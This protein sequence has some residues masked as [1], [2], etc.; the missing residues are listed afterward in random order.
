MMAGAFCGG[1]P[2]GNGP[3]FTVTKKDRL[4]VVESSGGKKGRSAE[5]IAESKRNY[6][7]I[8]NRPADVSNMLPNDIKA[9]IKQLYARILKIEGEKYD[10]EKRKDRQEYDLKEMESRRQQEARNKAMKMGVSEDELQIGKHPPKVLVASKFDRQVD[11]RG[12]GDKRELY[13]NPFVKPQ[14]SIAHGSGRP[15]TE[16]GRRELEEL[17]NIRKNLEPPKYVEQV[18]AEGDEARPPVPVIPM[19]IPSGDFAEAPQQ[20]TAPP[21]AAPKKRVRI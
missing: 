13:E 2:E 10:L 19:Q 8:V 6:M 18:K 15:P 16:W 9:K 3:N 20:E 4:G 11:R 14:P 7:T 12:Y 5:Q 21:P 1:T 17:E